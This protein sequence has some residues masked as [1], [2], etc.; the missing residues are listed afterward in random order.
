MHQN[1][2]TWRSDFTSEIPEVPQMRNAKPLWRPGG[3]RLPP[4]VPTRTP[5]CP[6]AVTQST[7]VFPIRGVGGL[8]GGILRV[9]LIGRDLSYYPV[10]SPRY[11]SERVN[12][13]IRILYAT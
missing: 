4:P 8:V 2:I 1:T 5:S 6:S 9:L 11:R 13:L 7:N 12:K 3:K 10:L